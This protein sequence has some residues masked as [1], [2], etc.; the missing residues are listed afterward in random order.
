MR[1]ML[2]RRLRRLRPWGVDVASGVEASAGKK[3]PERLRAFVAAAR[4]AGSREEL[5]AEPWLP[6]YIETH[7]VFLQPA[8]YPVVPLLA[9]RSGI[10]GVVSHGLKR[11]TCDF[12]IPRA[13][14]E[15]V[16]A[17]VFCGSE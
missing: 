2:A 12:K 1:R 4:A 14:T 6:V 17:F 9:F 15:K 16:A 8:I 7:E 10:G 13:A 5:V 3:D 11:S